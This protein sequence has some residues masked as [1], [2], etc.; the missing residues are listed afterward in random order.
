MDII[1]RNEE[2][3][4][5]AQVRSVLKAAFPTEAESE[6]VGL[7]RTNGK[8]VVSLVAV[9]GDDVMGHI[10][11]SPVST[12]PPGDAKGI[13][14]APVAVR[15]DVQV[16]GIG[17]ALIRT[18]LELAQELRFD[19]C[20]VLGDPNYYERFGF[21]TASD[22]GLRNEYGVDKEFMVTHFSKCEVVGL[23]RYLPE[24]AQLSV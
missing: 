7:L 1:I 12:S 5:F 16:Q 15:P 8:A 13:G 23:V 4:D 11:F 17:S 9:C 3:R 6:L 22:F 21:D 20:V 24:F 18:G 10:L 2:P 14:L 19:Y